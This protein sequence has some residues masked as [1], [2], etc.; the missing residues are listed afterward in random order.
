MR[1][2]ELPSQKLTIFSLVMTAL[3]FSSLRPSF[4]SQ[5]RQDMVKRI[6]EVEEAVSL[7]GGVVKIGPRRGATGRRREQD[8]ALAFD[9]VPVPVAARDEPQVAVG[10]EGQHLVGVLYA[11][12]FG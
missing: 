11:V 8:V 1:C 6:S 9:L 3:V 10:E 7:L 2:I 5:D 12:L 4:A